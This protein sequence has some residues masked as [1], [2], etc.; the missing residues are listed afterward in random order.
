MTKRNIENYIYRIPNL[1]NDSECKQA[2]KELQTKHG[3]EEG[4]RTILETYNGLHGS[5]QHYN[6]G[7]HGEM[8]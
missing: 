2:V 5:D 6:L 3:T 4:N 8:F 1:L 7:Q